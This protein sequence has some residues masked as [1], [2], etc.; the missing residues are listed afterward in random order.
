[1]KT[2]KIFN[3]ISFLAIILL[4]VIITAITYMHPLYPDD[5]NYAFVFGT[6]VRI[7][8]FKEILESVQTFYLKWGGRILPFMLGQLMI[9]WGRWIFSALNGVMFLALVILIYISCFKNKGD[10]TDFRKILLVIFFALI[11]LPVFAETVFW[12][13]GSINYLWMMVLILIYIYPYLF[14]FLEKGKIR[15]EFKTYILI[16]IVALLAGNTNEN[17]VP[18]VAF[19]TI[20]YLT[21]RKVTKKKIQK[22]NIFGLVFYLLGSGIL[23]LAPGN[24]NR[25]LVECSAYNISPDFVTRIKGIFW[26][27]FKFVIGN[28]YR[29]ILLIFLFVAVVYLF[30]N[31]Y[32]NKE[33]V[34]SM[35][36]VLAAIGTN[37]IMIFPSTYSARAGFGGSV[38]I[39]MGIC[40]LI[41]KLNIVEKQIDRYYTV[42]TLIIILAIPRI[43]ASTLKSAIEYN[44][45]YTSLIQYVIEEKEKGNLDIVVEPIHINSTRLFEGSELTTDKDNIQNFYFAKFY[46]INSI[47]VK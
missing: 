10:K 36:L 29:Y 31:G 6:N 28:Q 12:K 20:V 2:K 42:I 40:L 11:G 35:L 46:E 14:S 47:V 33:F 1:M 3:I 22:W 32:K 27:S 26:P 4:F 16:S 23:L 38:F 39:I 15:D 43:F 34:L 8:S 21:Y 7:D 13:S 18:F 5:Y 41:S 9:W 25:A 17:V 45:K 24:A 44:E 37:I 30:L 19:A